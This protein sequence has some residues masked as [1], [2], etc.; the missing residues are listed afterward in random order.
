MGRGLVGI[1]W[2]RWTIFRD[3]G[4]SLSIIMAPRLA[5]LPLP[6]VGNEDYLLYW[7]LRLWG[8]LVGASG[9]RAWKSQ[10]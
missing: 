7:L 8:T 6:G 1:D 4:L 10:Y 5:F 3:C 9:S 2:G